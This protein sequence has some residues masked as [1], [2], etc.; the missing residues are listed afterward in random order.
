MS[1]PDSPPQGSARAE[2]MRRAMRVLSAIFALIAVT[3]AIATIVVPPQLPAADAPSQLLAVAVHLDPSRYLEHYEPTNALSTQAFVSLT[4]LVARF[5]GVDV[6]WRVV[7]TIALLCQ[8]IGLGF[9]ARRLGASVPA[10]VALGAAGFVGWIYVVGFFSFAIALA[11]GAL[12]WACWVRRNEHAAYVVATALLLGCGAWAHAFAASLLVAHLAITAL[13][14]RRTDRVQAAH[15]AALVPAIAYIAWVAKAVAASPALVALRNASVSLSAQEAITLATDASLVGY[16]RYGAALVG[17][18]LLA[19]VL[20]IVRR[21][22]GD[23]AARR[24]GELGRMTLIWLLAFVAM[25]LHAFGFLFLAPRVLVMAMV[26]AVAGAVRPGANAALVTAIAAGALA[27]G[28]PNAR[29]E[30]QRVQDA[31][32]RYPDEPIGRAYAV[33]Y[34]PEP[35]TRIA[36]FALPFVGTPLLAA[37]RSSAWMPGANAADSPLHAMRFAAARELG[38]SAASNPY[39]IVPQ[40]CLLD[41]QCVANDL[42]RADQIAVA[43]ADWEAVVLAGVSQ[44]LIDRLVVRGYVPVGTSPLVLRSRASA[45]ILPYELPMIAR[46]APIIARVGLPETLGWYREAVI[47]ASADRPV[48]VLIRLDGLVAGPS[49]FQI[50]ADLDGDGELSDADY[51][52]VRDRQYSIEANA[53]IQMQPDPSFGGPLR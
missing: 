18:A 43:G 32:V 14:T 13:L 3:F 12:A 26:F 47:E 34:H 6:A 19:A 49:A 52:I 11:V 45:S 2:T 10:A 30:G 29:F 1:T 22:S 17:A 39:M 31:V 44:P 23:D 28:L 5:T 40:S 50:F 53:A 21:R 36:P 33:V 27:Y 24:R 51:P 7:L 42:Y 9:V 37:A 41:A 25:P 15:F 48:N 38:G 46:N 16:S 4:T 20:S 35:M 8:V